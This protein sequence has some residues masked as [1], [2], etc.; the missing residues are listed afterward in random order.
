MSDVSSI[1]E[2]IPKDTISLNGYK[3][4]D[5]SAFPSHWDDA[6]IRD[7]ARRPGWI[8]Y[9]PWNGAAG[10]LEETEIEGLLYNW[11]VWHDGLV[12]AL[13]LLNRDSEHDDDQ[14]GAI[15]SI[16]WAMRT[17]QSEYL[18]ILEFISK[19]RDNW[20]VPEPCADVRPAEVAS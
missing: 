11:Y 16:R 8:R 18:D 14:E 3:S 1:K 2:R 12:T 19:T 9:Y 17:M 20:E 5:R 4:V 10:Y 13:E 15:N 6:F 7:L